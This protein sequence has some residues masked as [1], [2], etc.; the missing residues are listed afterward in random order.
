MNKKKVI[1]VII[2]LIILSIVFLLRKEFLQNKDQACVVSIH[3][4]LIS[5]KDFF[6]EKATEDWKELDKNTKD[7]FLSSIAKSSSLDC[8]NKDDNEIPVDSWGKSFRIAYKISNGEKKQYIVWSNGS[9]GVSSTQD[10]IISPY[11]NKPPF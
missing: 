8:R 9:D 11:E 6:T 2:L 10:D 1:I 3:Q 7:K 5:K 4:S